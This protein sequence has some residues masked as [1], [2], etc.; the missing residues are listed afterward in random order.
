[1]SVKLLL[2]PHVPSGETIGD[3]TNTIYMH[4][5]YGLGF[6]VNPPYDAPYSALEGDSGT[7]H[8]IGA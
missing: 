5:K 6:Y 8:M 4:V 3:L 2:H 1:M 7:L